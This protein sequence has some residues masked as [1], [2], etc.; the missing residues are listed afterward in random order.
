MTVLN[1]AVFI[2]NQY[3]INER[4]FIVANKRSKTNYSMNCDGTFWHVKGVGVGVGEWGL[5]A[6]YRK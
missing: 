4:R 6:I 1:K 5:D 3:F 2:I